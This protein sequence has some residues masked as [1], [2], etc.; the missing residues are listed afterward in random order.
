MR[1]FRSKSDRKLK[2]EVRGQR[3][4][5]RGERSE[6]MSR[7]AEEQRW[8]APSFLYALAPQ[9]LR[10]ASLTSDFGL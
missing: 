9:L 2:A 5:V 10:S 7:G 1:G 8:F 3:S 4:E 6:Q